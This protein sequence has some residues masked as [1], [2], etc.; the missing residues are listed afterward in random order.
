M[1]KHA[2]KK[3]TD[4]SFQVGDMVYLKMQPHR[5]QALGTGNPLKLASKWYG[6]FRVL[7][8]VGHRAYKLQLPEGSQIHD[9][10]HVNQLKK[11]L[12]P[13]AVPNPNLPLVTPT[14]KLKQ[15]P[16]AI[17]QRRQVPRTAGDYDRSEE[18]RVGKE[19]LL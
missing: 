17:L 7:Q 4:R 10:F 5:E 12:G 1:K 19:C 9:V 18:R 3:H 8:T 13:N 15:T 16:V 6:P 11:H 14:G 2:D